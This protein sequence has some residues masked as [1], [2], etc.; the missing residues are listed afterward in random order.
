MG[1]SPE[2]GSVWPSTYC[3]AV[4]LEPSAAFALEVWAFARSLASSPLLIDQPWQ[5][6]LSVVTST[7]TAM[8]CRSAGGGGLQ[9]WDGQRVV[10]D[11]RLRVSDTSLV[12]QARAPRGG[13][14]SAT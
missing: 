11:P 6:R 8:K 9:V 14:C 13:R 3:R 12:P 1:P 5:D 7:A 2:D 4:L 10:Q